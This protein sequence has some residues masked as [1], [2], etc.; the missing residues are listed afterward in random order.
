MTTVEKIRFQEQ[1]FVLVGG[2]IT[3][4]EAYRTGEV[5]FAHLMKDGSVRRFGTVIGQREDIEFLGEET[6]AEP[7]SMLALWNMLNWPMPF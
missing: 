5:S 4:P 6:I 3:T 1:D 2:A 7:D